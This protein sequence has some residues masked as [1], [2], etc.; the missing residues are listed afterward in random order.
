MQTYNVKIAGTLEATA[1]VGLFTVINGSVQASLLTE[2]D[3]EGMG[4]SSA[5]NEFG[6]YRVGTAGVTGS[7]A[8][9]FTPTNPGYTAYAGT[10]FAAYSTQPIKGALLHNVPL[11]ANGQRY[12]WRANPNLNNAIAIPA[13]NVA[14]AS[15]AGFTISGTSVIAGRLQLATIA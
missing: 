12:F 13:G 3:V 6:I 9:T 5:A 1:L 14:A 8:L 7:S 10:G 2:I 15:I 11:N 4:T